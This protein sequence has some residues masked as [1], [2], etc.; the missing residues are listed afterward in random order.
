[1]INTIH[2]ERKCL[3][4][5]K[6]NIKHISYAVVLSNQEIMKI[7]NI[8]PS[9]ASKIKRCIEIEIRKKYPDKFIPAHCVP[10]KD[11]IKYFDIDIEFLKRL[12]SI[13]LDGTEK[14]T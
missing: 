3:D 12:A 10:T 13:D 7:A 11:V 1:M 8:S 9:T 5:S 4:E 14:Q 2:F 6:R